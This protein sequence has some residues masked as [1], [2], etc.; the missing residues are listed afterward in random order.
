MKL[1]TIVALFQ[2]SMIVECIWLAA[3]IQ[4]IILG[5]GAIL[6]AFNSDVLDNVQPIE[7]KYWLTSKDDEDQDQE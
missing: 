1:I 4:P 3:A 6:T 7:W 5:F 2:L